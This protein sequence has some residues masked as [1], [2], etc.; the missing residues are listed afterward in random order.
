MRDRVSAQFTW[1]FILAISIF[2]R[3]L[4]KIRIKKRKEIDETVGIVPKTGRRVFRISFLKLF[5]LSNWLSIIPFKLDW[6]RT[7]HEIS[8]IHGSIRNWIYLK[9]RFVITNSCSFV[10]WNTVLFLFHM[11][12]IA[13]MFVQI[14]NWTKTMH[15][16]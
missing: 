2:N 11:E 5:W 7:F 14:M 16:W 13:L 3:T 10:W 12:I 9:F 6:S 4:V 1:D 8:N 15:D